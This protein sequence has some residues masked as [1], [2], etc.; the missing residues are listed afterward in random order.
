MTRKI[1]RPNKPFR[2]GQLVRFSG[3]FVNRHPLQFLTKSGF[4]KRL[5]NEPYLFSDT[6]RVPCEEIGLV[7]A[8]VPPMS[9]DIYYV[10]FFGEI[11]ATVPV[12]FLRS[13]RGRKM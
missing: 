7:I 13:M 2:P 11:I 9:G 12:G 6:V 4:V 1:S 10:L 3:R 8:V 5:N